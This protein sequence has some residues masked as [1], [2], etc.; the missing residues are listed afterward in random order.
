MTN[1]QCTQDYLQHKKSNWQPVDRKGVRGSRNVTTNLFYQT[2]QV[3]LSHNVEFEF[4]STT[5]TPTK[6]YYLVTFRKNKKQY[7]K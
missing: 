6:Y 1:V 5:L 4:K 3:C 2:I 7:A